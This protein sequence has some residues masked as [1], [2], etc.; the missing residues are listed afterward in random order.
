[1]KI[2][3]VILC[4]FLMTGVVLASCSKNND[5]KLNDQDEDFLVKASISN[6]AEVSAAT[7]AASKATNAAVKTFAQHMLGT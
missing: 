4:G 6:S 7:L 5:D 1:M 2:Q 3:K